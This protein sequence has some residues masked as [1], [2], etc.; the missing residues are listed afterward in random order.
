MPENHMI[1]SFP[2]SSIS[3]REKPEILIFFHMPKTGGTTMDGILGRCFPA[4]QRFDG[5]MADDQSAL[6][7]RPRDKIEQ[8]Y[9]ALSASQRTQIRCLMGTIYPMGIHTMLD[10]PARYF[11]LLRPP[12]ERIVSH[13]I[14]KRKL[15]HQPFYHRIKNMTLEEYLDAGIGIESYDYQVR[16]LSGCPELD[17]TLHPT[18]A[19]IDAPPVKRWHLELAK[20]NIERYFLAAAPLESF[21]KLLFLLRNVYGWKLRQI[22][23]VRRNVGRDGSASSEPISE[24]IRRRL[25]ETNRYDTELYE[26]VK[27]RFDQQTRALEPGLSRDLQLFEI[28]NSAAAAVR[29]TTPEPIARSI[30]HLLSLKRAA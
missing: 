14:D 25:E 15:P 13:F 18:G 12:V 30:S 4:Y 11:T 7:I 8:R 19:R 24:S 2:T 10:R 22:L 6:S 9:L 1:G 23:F 21:T 20:R 28:L 3:L 29:R 16:L 17:T 27:V 26:W 5:A